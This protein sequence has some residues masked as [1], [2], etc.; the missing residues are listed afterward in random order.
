MTL[1]TIKLQ[2][3]KNI[4]QFACKYT[5]AIQYTLLETHT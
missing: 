3:K 1:Y 2:K 4:A 5:S